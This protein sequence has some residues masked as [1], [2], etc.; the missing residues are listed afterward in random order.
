MYTKHISTF[1][2]EFRTNHETFIANHCK[3]KSPINY[4]IELLD[5][6][7][8]GECHIKVSYCQN[9]KLTIGRASLLLAM[10]TIAGYTNN[11]LDCGCTFTMGW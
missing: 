4:E 9:P 7:N 3:N 5:Y 11:E 6:S 1:L 2:K 8:T 10:D